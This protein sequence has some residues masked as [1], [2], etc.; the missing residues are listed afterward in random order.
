MGYF[1]FGKNTT[2]TS[3]KILYCCLIF[4]IPTHKWFFY[5]L[6]STISLHHSFVHY[7]T[8][9]CV[10]AYFHKIQGTNIFQNKSAYWTFSNVKVIAKK[11]NPEKTWYT[12]WLFVAELRSKPFSCDIHVINVHIA[13]LNSKQSCVISTTFALRPP[14]EVF[15]WLHNADFCTDMHLFLSSSSLI[16]TKPCGLQL[17]DLLWYFHSYIIYLWIPHPVV[18]LHWQITVFCFRTSLLGYPF[19]KMTRIYIFLVPSYRNPYSFL[20]QTSALNFL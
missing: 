16:I 6:I 11:K 17:S 7:C 3:L 1:V 2:F 18:F 12:L 20:S 8:K 19:N 5:S 15:I 14:L 13:D 10:T 4:S 9:I